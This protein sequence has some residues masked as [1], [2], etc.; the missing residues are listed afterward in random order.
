MKDRSWEPVI[1]LEVHVQVATATKLFC[2]CP[3]R[4]AAEPNT[5]V[6]PV[7]LGLPGSLP[8]LNRAAL[9]LG[10]RA[11]LALGCRVAPR[12]RFDRKNYFYPDLPKGYQ[13]TQ[14]DHP[15]AL[16]GGVEI[17]SGRVIPLER[18]H[19]EEDAG[20]SIHTGR[21]ETLVDLNRCGVPLLEI[22]TLPEIRSPAEAHQY[23]DA[24]K[25][26][27]RY[28]RVSECDMEKGSLRCDAN[29]SLRRP[30]V[31]ELGAKVEIKNLNS[32]K[33]VERALAFEVERQA[34]L[35][36][37]GGSVRRE[38]RLWD[39][40]KGETRPMRS[41]EEA[42]DYRY[43]PEPDIPPV[44]IP[45]ALVE[46]IR[47]ALP[48]SP[49]SRLKRLTS[50]QGISEREARILVSRREA[51]DLFEE[52]LRAGA[53]PA[54]AARWILGEV[55]RLAGEGVLLLEGGKVTGKGLA[56]LIS[57]VESGTATAQAAKKILRRMAVAGGDPARLLEEMGL[58]RMEG[59]KELEEVARRVLAENP[60]PVESYRKGKVTALKALVGQVMRATR[61]RA[62]PV[63]AARIL[64]RLL[65]G[66]E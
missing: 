15:F 20:K 11:A 59:E 12:T 45:P 66:E 44:E 37:S 57:L 18:I 63:R 61:G 34:A 22:V 8:V 6:C 58:G 13:I 31:G 14:K 52:A 56:G 27:L 33:A 26:A 35:L 38:T 41:K 54:A 62:D 64:E 32:F 55:L 30:G 53:A 17:P 9:E 49:A 19:L 3:Y 16:G 47:A 4:F 23:L 39:E 5:L 25:L 2:S 29:I 48:E 24:L 21:G 65:G 43:F 1:G 50:V 10:I 28:A 7:C 51:A 42:Q 40:K 36:D 46:E 60:G